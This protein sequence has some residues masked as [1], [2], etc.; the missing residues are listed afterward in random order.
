MAFADLETRSSISFEQRCLEQRGGS[1]VSITHQ[2][3]DNFYTFPI[4]RIFTPDT[5][6]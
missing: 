2:T 3:P 4:S 6:T 5:Y 1:G